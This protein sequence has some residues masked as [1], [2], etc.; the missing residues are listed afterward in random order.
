MSLPRVLKNFIVFNDGTGYLGEV[1]EA[2]PPKLSRK[3]EEYRAGGMNGPISID[4]GMEALEFEWTAAGY[5]SSLLT[6]WGA[7]THDAVLLRFAGAIQ[8]D[9]TGEV[10]ALEIVMRGR[11]KEIDSGNAK[12][13]EKTEIKVKSALSYYKL[14]INGEVIM[15]IDFVNFIEVIGGVDRMAQIRLALG[16][17]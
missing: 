9:D 14:S 2:T 8:S 6:Q 17:F 13:G 1:P 10:Q 3:M 4:L 12:P 15:E 16:L 5:M 7:P 11:H